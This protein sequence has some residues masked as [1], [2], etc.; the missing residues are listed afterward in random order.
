MT[1]RWIAFAACCALL[2]GCFQAPDVPRERLP[3][4]VEPASAAPR[5]ALVL[6]SGGPR[7]FAHIGVLKALEQ[8]GIRCDLIVGSSVGSMVGALYASGMR[9]PEMEKLAYGLNV[10][11]LMEWRTLG[12]GV[13]SGAA[14]ENFVNA[15]VHGAPIERLKIE[16]VAA[17]T[18][19]RDRKLVLFNRGDTGLAVRASG[20]S[21]GQ[22]E[23]VRIGDELYVDADEAS[24]VPIRVAR[25]LGAR[26]VIAVDVS[27]YLADTPASAPREWVVKDERRARQIAAE[28]PLADV[29]VH[30]NLGYYAGHTEDYRRRVIALAEKAT[31]EKL[32]AIQAAI[33]RAG[34]ARPQNA[35]TARMPAG[36]ASR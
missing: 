25:E 16:F 11:E 1:R 32:P 5:I 20:A 27:A 18:R 36:E 6:G 26:V 19:L 28:A 15:R 23:P 22:F 31:L 3:R 24:P 35:S 17:A 30:P 29:M 12:G 9:A 33:A 14:V 7:G 2:G 8:S 13:A 10:L 4:F 34:I 21:P